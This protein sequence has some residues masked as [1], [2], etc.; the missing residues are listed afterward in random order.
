[1]KCS[2]SGNRPHRH[3]S[4]PPPPSPQAIW[5]V[6]GAD[7]ELLKLKTYVQVKFNPPEGLGRHGDSGHRR[8]CPAWPV[9]TD[10]NELICG[11]SQGELHLYPAECVS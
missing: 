6:R 7:R 10:N 1:M 9:G 3:P 5:G 4:G 8:G 11:V 2:F